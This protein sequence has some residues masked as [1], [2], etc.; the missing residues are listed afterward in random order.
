MFKLK[1]YPRQP[2]QPLKRIEGCRGVYAPASNEAVVVA[3]EVIHRSEAYLRYVAE[4]ECFIC[5]VEGWSQAAHENYGKAKQRKVCDS[6]VFP[7][8]CPR[9]GLMGC[10]QQFDI[11][12]EYTRD[13]RRELGVRLSAKMRER[14]VADGWRFTSKGIT[15]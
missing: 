2:K 10:H 8:C 11:G 15:R 9:Y 6:R 3:K 4:Q 5:G 7:A 13:E 1:P 12:L 14:A